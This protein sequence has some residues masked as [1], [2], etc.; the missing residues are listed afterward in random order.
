MQNLIRKHN[1]KNTE[2]GKEHLLVFT[3][4]TGSDLYKNV[5]M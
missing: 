2:Y 5:K 4:C 1:I 3:N